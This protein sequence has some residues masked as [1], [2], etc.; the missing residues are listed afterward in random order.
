MTEEIMENIFRI[1]IEL[2]RSPLRALNAYLIRGDGRNLLID[3][4][5]NHPNCKAAM[6]S[7]LGELGADMRH[8]D[9]L[10]THM[11]SDHSGLA[12]EI[13]SEQTIVYVPRGDLPRL[14]GKSRTALWAD[15]TAAMLHAG[16]PEAEAAD[17]RTFATSRA[18]AADPAFDR[19]EP[20]DEGNLF[21]CGEYIL[22][23][24]SAPGHT[25]VQLCFWMREQGVLFTADHVLFDITPNIT[26]WS[27]VRDSLGDY[28]DS[29]RKIDSYDVRLALPGHRQTGDFHARIAALLRHHESRLNECIGVV[30]ENPGL[31]PYEIAAKLTWNVRVNSWDEF[32]ANQKWFAVGETLSHLQHLEVL[33]MVERERRYGLDRY[34]CHNKTLQFKI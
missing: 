11:H 5:F 31:T 30:Q 10:L 32:P 14:M 29:L 33:G 19:Y 9:I 18:M 8:T 2:P 28:L 1:P 16:F 20:M 27:D 3:T 26:A 21:P 23:A 13:A 4:G 7:A 15:D 22:K 25:P 24:V 6:L 34:Y 12:P 17:P